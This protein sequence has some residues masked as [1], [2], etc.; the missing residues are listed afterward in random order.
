MDAPSE[1]AMPRY[2]PLT[3][4]D[5]LEQIDRRTQEIPYTAVKLSASSKVSESQC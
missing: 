1:H 5:P 2:I 3:R 4:V